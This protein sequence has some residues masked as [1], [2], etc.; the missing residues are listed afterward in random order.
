MLLKN[1][2]D[3]IEWIWLGLSVPVFVILQFIAAPFG[4]H[5]K[6]NFGPTINNKFAWV[7]MES[8]SF[9]TMAYFFMTGTGP[10]PLVSWLIVFL[11]LGHYFNRSFVYALRQKNSQE[12]MPVLIFLMAIGFNLMNAGLNGYY[13]GYL[14]TYTNSWFL[15]VNF[16][17]GLVLFVGGM[18]VNIKSDNMLLSLRKP[19]E[20]GYKIPQG[21]LFKYVSCPNH[22]GEIVEWIGFA[23]LT[24]NPASL[25][26][27]VWTFANVAP[28]SIAHHKW[29]KT[30]FENYPSD[31]RALIPFVW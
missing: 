17:V 19:G 1:N 24:L 14:A 30:K 5:I 3:T 9:V 27:A 6:R 4:R 21:F 16:W 25:S 23:V 2:F 7:V 26:F 15:Q 13:L 31:R 29:Y 20:S 28:R 11:W 10:K 12:Q 22:L 18:F 8:V